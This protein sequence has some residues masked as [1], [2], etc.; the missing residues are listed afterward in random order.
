MIYFTSVIHICNLTYLQSIF[1]DYYYRRIYYR[2]AVSSQI[3]PLPDAPRLA[4]RNAMKRY[5]RTV[6]RRFQ[7]CSTLLLRGINIHLPPTSENSFAMRACHR[8]S[9]IMTDCCT[10]RGITLRTTGL[11]ICDNA[12]G[13]TTR[14]SFGKTGTRFTTAKIRLCLAIATSR[15]VGVESI[16][17]F[18]IVRLFYVNP[19]STLCNLSFFFI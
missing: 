19:K 4:T 18:V 3:A 2:D 13:N 16:L 14:K 15:R 11:Q 5:S 9:L 6:Y 12:I 1:V 10:S 7:G 8:P 17:L